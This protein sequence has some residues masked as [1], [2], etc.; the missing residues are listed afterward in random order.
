MKVYCPNCKCRL[1]DC[2]PPILELLSCNL[3]YKHFCEFCHE[4]H[5]DEHNFFT[6]LDYA[7]FVNDTK[8]ESTVKELENKLVHHIKSIRSIKSQIHEKRGDFDRYTE[9]GDCY[10]HKNCVI[11][12]KPNSSKNIHRNVTSL[13]TQNIFRN[14]ITPDF[15]NVGNN[16]F[17]Q[18]NFGFNLSTP[19]AD[20]SEF[21]LCTKT[22]VVC[23]KG[24]GCRN[25]YQCSICDGVHFTKKEARKQR[26]YR[27]SKNA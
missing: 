12:N 6:K 7:K 18:R 17:L 8:K 9:I 19:G 13:T 26:K 27:E 4:K 5:M 24:V 10:Q 20:F 1:S 22:D 2:I 15:I 16:N 11:Y 3:C 14:I 23:T 21:K 25:H